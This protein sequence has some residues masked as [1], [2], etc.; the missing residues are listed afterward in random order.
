M[1]F[2]LCVASRESNSGSPILSISDL[3]RF[4]PPG[5]RIVLAGVCQGKKLHQAAAGLYAAAFAADPDRK[6]VV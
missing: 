4:P 1:Q 6:S 3:S 5:E 2:E